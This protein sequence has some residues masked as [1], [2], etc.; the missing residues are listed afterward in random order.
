MF[1][2]LLFISPGSVVI[3]M[4]SLAKQLAEPAGASIF[5]AVTDDFYCLAPAFFRISIFSCLSATSII[6]S[7]KAIFR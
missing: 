3:R 2:G 4:A 5:I 1:Y 6:V 7:N